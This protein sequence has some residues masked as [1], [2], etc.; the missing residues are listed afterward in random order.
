MTTAELVHRQR[1]RGFPRI[2]VYQLRTWLLELAEQG[3]L[4]EHAPDEWRPTP[5]GQAWFA[6]VREFVPEDSARVGVPDPGAGR[7]LEAA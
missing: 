2:A 3:Y 5:L 1:V 7:A 4:V 6:G